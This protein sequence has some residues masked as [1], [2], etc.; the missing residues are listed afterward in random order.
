MIFYQV[1]D[2]GGEI[3]FGRDRRGI[4]RRRGMIR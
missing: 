4:D 2:S 3:H 1:T